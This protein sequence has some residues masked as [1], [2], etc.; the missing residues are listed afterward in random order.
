MQKLD[1]TTLNLLK[2][3]VIKGNK[4][5]LPPEQLPRPVYEAVNTVLTNL[6]GKWVGGKT[7][8]HVFDY[9]PTAA[10]NAVITS[11][12]IPP[13]NPTAYYWTVLDIVAT[14]FSFVSPYNRATIL[15]PSAG[16]GHIADAIMGYAPKAILTTVELEPLNVALLQAKGYNPIAHDF[17]TW[18]TAQR[19]DLIY[20]NP[21]F[22]TPGQKDC[23]IAHIQHAHSLLNARGEMVAITPRSWQYRTDKK[24]QQWREWLY[25]YMI[26]GTDL[27]G[28]A[29]KG[30]GTGVATTMLHIGANTDWKTKPYNGYPTRSIFNALLWLENDHTDYT[31]LCKLTDLAMFTDYVKQVIAKVNREHYEGIHLQAGDYAHIYNHIHNPDN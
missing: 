15:E 9:D 21:P 31:A 11:A 13:N 5:Y 28:D 18:T 20:M 22:S 17:L 30:A 4:V 12:I 10:I 1:E 8:A 29:F 27:P 16:T 6:R 14:M 25:E 2:N 7:Q 24:H 19:Y 26:G 23:Y 3:S